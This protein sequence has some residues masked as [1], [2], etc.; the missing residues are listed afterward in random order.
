MLSGMCYDDV[1]R[2][3]ETDYGLTVKDDGP[4]YMITYEKRNRA[5]KGRRAAEAAS[6]DEAAGAVETAPLPPLVDLTSPLVKQCRGLILEKETNRVVCQTFNRMEKLPSEITTDALLTALN[7]DWS[8]VKV[9]D[10]IDG[11]QIKLYY[12]AGEWR[13]GTTRAI[14]AHKAF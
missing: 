5:R 2:M 1:K 7:G 10:A 6:A 9:Q 3:F 13:V 8:S 4:L 11:S 14:D 12:Y